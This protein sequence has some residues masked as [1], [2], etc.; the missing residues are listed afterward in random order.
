MFWWILS[1]LGVDWGGG[2]SSSELSDQKYVVRK[3]YARGT[4]HLTYR[5][6]ER[7]VAGEGVPS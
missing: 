2:E 1:D 7:V 6:L 5:S 4:L 3:T